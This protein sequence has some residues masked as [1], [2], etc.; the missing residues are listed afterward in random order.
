MSQF[1]FKQYVKDTITGNKGYIVILDRSVIC[2]N[3][4]LDSSGLHTCCFPLNIQPLIFSPQELDQQ[5]RDQQQREQ[6]AEKYL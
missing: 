5:Q 6:Y 1:H 3:S 4:K 2:I